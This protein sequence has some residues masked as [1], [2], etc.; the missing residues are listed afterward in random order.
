MRK[1]VKSILKKWTKFEV[2]DEVAMA[3]AREGGNMNEDNIED[4]RS[5]NT[6]M[7]DYLMVEVVAVP[8]SFQIENHLKMRE[9]AGIFENEK[10]DLKQLGLISEGVKASPIFSILNNPQ[11]EPQ[12]CMYFLKIMEELNLIIKS[13]DNPIKRNRE[14]YDVF[15]KNWSDQKYNYVRGQDVMKM[16]FIVINLVP[17][18]QQHVMDEAVE[19][20]N[21]VLKH[22]ADVRHMKESI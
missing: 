8:E 6:R 10:I 3:K 17:L 2:G 13:V 1:K 22:T 5:L 20:V 4:F 7:N 12:T 19:A 18:Y 16:N 14:E 21:A 11:L 9:A 15:L